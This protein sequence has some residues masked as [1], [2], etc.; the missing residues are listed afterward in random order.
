MGNLNID[1]GRNRM[2]YVH[3]SGSCIGFLMSRGPKGVEAFD[4]DQ[5][6]LGH[7]TDQHAAAA[8]VEQSGEGRHSTDTFRTKITSVDNLACGFSH[9]RLRPLRIL[10]APAIRDSSRSLECDLTCQ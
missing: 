10:R 4:I 9:S 7:F 6:S 5:I 1:F 2:V 3:R 8:G